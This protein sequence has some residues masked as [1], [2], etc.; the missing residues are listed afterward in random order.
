ML[1]GCS[2][3]PTKVH[4]PISE[5]ANCRNEGTSL[6]NGKDPFTSGTM[7]FYQS[8]MDCCDELSTSGGSTS[9]GYGRSST[10]SNSSN[11]MNTLNGN[12]S[13]LVHLDAGLISPTRQLFRE[14]LLSKPNHT[15]TSNCSTSPGNIGSG[16]SSALESLSAESPGSNFI[17]SQLSAV[18]AEL[19]DLDDLPKLISL[20]NTSSHHNMLQQSDTSLDFFTEYSQRTNLNNIFDEERSVTT[21]SSSI[22]SNAS[23]FT[24]S[25]VTPPSVSSN[26]C[27]TIT[28]DNSQDCSFGGKFEPRSALMLDKRSTAVEVASACLNESFLSTPSTSSGSVF[29]HNSPPVAS[30]VDRDLLY[31][32]I[33][34][35]VGFFSF[36][37]NATAIRFLLLSTVMLS[38]HRGFGH[39]N[40]RAQLIF[41][42]LYSFF[43]S[44]VYEPLTFF[45]PTT[46]PR[47]SLYCQSTGFSWTHQSRWI[48]T[49]TKR[50]FAYTGLCGFPKWNQ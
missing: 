11:G 29:N 3:Q 48:A 35:Y 17:N 50:S 25:S 33:I 23:N 15:P 8:V 6:S 21:K 27:F 5:S 19:C 1:P 28:M 26:Q 43:S 46:V 13:G 10:T 39:T 18:A 34:R 41:N 24:I 31:R 20:S 36:I 47:S 44:L 2:P 16:T 12:V 9:S 38:C 4:T 45:Q 14:A 37:I 30:L 32:L 22:D 49:L 42:C 7:H 40:C